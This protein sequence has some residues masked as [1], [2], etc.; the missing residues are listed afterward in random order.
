MKFQS[1]ALSKRE[2]II[3]AITGL[4]LVL[5]FVKSWYLVRAR[6]I[7]VLD[8]KIS[9]L[10]KQIDM[11][12]RIVQEMQTRKI[13]SVDKNGADEMIQYVRENSQLAQLVRRI[14]AEEDRFLVNRLTIDKQEVEKDYRRTFLKLEVE[15]PFM[16]IGGFLERLEASKTVGE[17]RNIEISRTGPEL[18]QCF[19]KITLETYVFE[20]DL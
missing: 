18:K 20:G 4:V 1:R 14:A 9:S 13:A 3:C 16:K 7:R 8:E 10:T 19:A 5:S 15:G 11:N 17:V 2:K 12:R 6:E